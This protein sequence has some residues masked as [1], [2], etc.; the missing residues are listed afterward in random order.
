MIEKLKEGSLN[1]WMCKFCFSKFFI[2]SSD[3]EDL[4][5]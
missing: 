1:E 3:D 5:I 4:F 2:L